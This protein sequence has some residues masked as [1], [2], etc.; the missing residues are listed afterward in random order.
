LT[1]EYE[2]YKNHKYCLKC[3]EVKKELIKTWEEFDALYQYV[4]NEVMGY[5]KKMALSSIMTMRLKGLSTGQVQYRTTNQRADYSYY[6]VLIAFKSKSLEIKK[7]IDTTKFKD[8]MHKFNYILKIVEPSI[9]D[10]VIRLK[11]QNK[12]E[13]KTNTIDFVLSDSNYIKISKP[14]KLTEVLKDLW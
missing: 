8:E 13:D 6:E 9:N 2:I 7:A 12:I 14:N 1:T 10:V 4:R 5:N 3:W 11:E